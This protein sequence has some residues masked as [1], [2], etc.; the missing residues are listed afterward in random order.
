[1]NIVNHLLNLHENQANLWPTRSI[2]LLKCVVVKMAPILPQIDIFG[3]IFDIW[4]VKPSPLVW[5]HQITPNALQWRSGCQN[6]NCKFKRRNCPKPKIWLGISYCYIKIHLLQK[7]G[8][9]QT[10]ISHVMA[11]RWFWQSKKLRHPQKHVHIIL[12]SFIKYQFPIKIQFIYCQ[13]SPGLLWEVVLLVCEVEAAV[14]VIWGMLLSSIRTGSPAK[15]LISLS[16]YIY[17]YIAN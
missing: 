17:I 15:S 2:K 8:Q 11:R 1:M 13:F 14:G 9:D 4:W 5:Y 3:S 16:I 12:K 6:L 7:F 10:N